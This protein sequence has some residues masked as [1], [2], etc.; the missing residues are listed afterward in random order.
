M[1][2]ILFISL[3]IAL[4]L[5][6]FVVKTAKHEPRKAKKQE[7]AEIMRQLLALSDRENNIS[8]T[9]PPLQPAIPRTSKRSQPQKPRPSRENVKSRSAAI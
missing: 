3:A 1:T 8:A 6:V 5:Y 9:A 7:K 2:S 4:V